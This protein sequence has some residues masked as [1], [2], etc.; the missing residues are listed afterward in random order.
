MKYIKSIFS[1]TIVF[2]VII[3]VISC[4]NSR[5]KGLEATGRLYERIDSLLHNAAANKEIPGAAAY[6]SLNGKEVYNKAFGW[7]NIE[8]EEPL[9]AN[10]IFRLASMTKGLTAVAVMQL[11]EEG[12]MHLDDEVSTY[13]PEFKNPR[14]L[15]EVLPD[16]GFTSRDAL[17]EITV[18]QLLTHTSGIGYGFQNEMYNALILKNN[19]SE[20]FEDDSRSSYENIRRIAKLP[21]LFEPGEQY[22][23]GLSYDVLGVV[24]EQVTGKRYD[25]YVEQ[26]ILDPLKMKNSYFFVPE[27][28]QY[29]LVSVY[30]PAENGTGLQPT[31]YPDNEYPVIST[32]KFFSGGSDLCSTAEDYAK[33]LQMLL[34]GG[35]YDKSRILGKPSVMAMLSKQ[36][37]FDDG[38]SD[39]GF[40]AWII[41]EK[42]ASAG[43]RGIGS[44]EF[45]GFYDTFSWA[46]PEQNM[47]AVLLLQMYP[48]NEHS[49]HQKFQREVYGLIQ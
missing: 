26:E 17:N 3:P 8:N 46:D 25:R 36:T 5:G 11:V 20:G 22:V 33:F 15:E 32:R 19:I 1:L 34:N 2:L 45:G 10:D 13:I 31:S 40:A 14:I 12:A 43:P 42:G 6:I 28:E 30:Q 47:V 48:T 44:F 29:R 38:N 27:K 24:I 9:L 35:T 4:I 16:S 18:R 37:P 7:R 23:Y 39:L 41:N 49:I 21:L